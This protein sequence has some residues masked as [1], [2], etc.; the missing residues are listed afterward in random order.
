MLIEQIIEL[1]LRESGPS[2]RT[3]TPTNVYFYDKTI[4]SKE[5]FRVDCYLLIN[6]ARGNA[7]YFPLPGPN[8]LQ[9]KFNTKMQD[10]KRVLD[11]NCQY[12]KDRTIYFFV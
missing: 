6:I 9:I 11:L 8:H 2:G 10:V 7:P 5:Y 1:R 12:K 4:I 3:C